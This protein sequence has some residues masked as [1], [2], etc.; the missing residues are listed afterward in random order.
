MELASARQSESELKS[1]L[2]TA[3]AEVQKNA[4]EWTV[5]KQKHDG[6]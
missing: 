5:L 1:Q 6:G 4:Q 2:A 3:V